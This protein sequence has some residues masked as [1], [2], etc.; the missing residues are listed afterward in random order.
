MTTRVFAQDTMSDEI[1]TNV[2][3]TTTLQLTN[4]VFFFQ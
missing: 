2:K 3:L 4:L 1:L